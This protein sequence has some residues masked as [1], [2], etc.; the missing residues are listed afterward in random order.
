MYF[1]IYAKDKADHLSLRMKTRPVHLEYLKEHA[2]KMLSVGPTMTDDGE[3][4][5]GSLLIMEFD[6]IE[7]AKE[8]A[9]G[10]PY[11]KAGLFETTD[12]HAWR[13]VKPKEL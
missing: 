12:V 7:Q 8:W 9:A 6:T 3:S 4:P 11:A 13:E 10:D 2:D 1:S 5:I